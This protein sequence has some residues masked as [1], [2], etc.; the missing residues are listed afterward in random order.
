MSDWAGTATPPSSSATASYVSIAELEAYIG[1]DPRAAAIALKAA[2]D[3][4]QLWYCQRATRII[5]AIP[6]KGQTYYDIGDGDNEQERQFPRWIDGV[7]HDETDTGDGAEVPQ[8]V[9]DACCEEAIA[10]YSHYSSTDE[11]ERLNLQAQGVKAYSLGGGYSET[12]GLS[13]SAKQKGLNSKEAYDLL[14]GYI[15][16]S[17][18][19]VVS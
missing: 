15:S 17:V 5:D 10:L 19:L 13:G 7:A 4:T 1:S 9:K 16:G 12:F 11:Q 8:A 2:A 18:E 6:F 14:R 3:A